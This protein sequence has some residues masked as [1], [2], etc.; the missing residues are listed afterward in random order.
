MGIWESGSL[1]T[2]G[3]GDIGKWG[4]GDLEAY[5]LHYFECVGTRV[6]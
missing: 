4:P 5:P 1:G 6:Y 2:W 3:T